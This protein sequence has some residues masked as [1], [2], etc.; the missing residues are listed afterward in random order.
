MMV[1]C[2]R[3]YQTEQSGQLSWWEA[4]PYQTGCQ[5]G[6]LVSAHALASAVVAGSSILMLYVLYLMLYVLYLCCMIG[7]FTAGRTEMK[8]TFVLSKYQGKDCK[9]HYI[10]VAS[11]KKQPS[12][13]K[14]T[15][16]TVAWLN[17][18][19]SCIYKAKVKLQLQSRWESSYKAIKGHKAIRGH[20]AVCAMGYQAVL[21]IANNQV[22]GYKAS[23]KK[24]CKVSQKK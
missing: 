3:T 20:K 2:V 17:S 1:A 23:W 18:I 21:Y 16:S 5:T 9:N 14:H 11:K 15:K 22:S 4:V 24:L 10:Y 13:A 19:A 8:P 12:L 6:R 7:C